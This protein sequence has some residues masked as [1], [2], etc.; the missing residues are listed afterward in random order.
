MS[1]KQLPEV[2]PAGVPGGVA[3]TPAFSEAAELRALCDQLYIAL[4]LCKE[5]VERGTFRYGKRSN[6]VKALAA[7][8][9]ILAAAWIENMKD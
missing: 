2:D 7:Y 1:A 9:R 8:D 4:Q 5:D 3:V 6:V